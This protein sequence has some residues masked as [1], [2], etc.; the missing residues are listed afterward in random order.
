MTVTKAKR[1][2]WYTRR[3]GVMRG[4]YPEKQISRYILL[5][6]IRDGDE[7]RPEGGAWQSLA[8]F[9]ELIPEIMKLPP[10]EENQ[11]KLLMAQMREDERRPGD[12]R[13]RAPNTPA[14]LL[15]RR[16]GQE[17]RSAEADETVRHR[18]L[19]EQV[20][21]PAHGGK[22]LYRYPAVASAIVLF[23]L[24]ASYLLRQTEPEFVPPDCSAGARPGVNW[25]NCNLSGLRAENASLIG[26]R[27]QNARL[28]SVHLAGAVMTG[29]DLEYSSVNLGDLERADL[30]HSNLRGASLRGSNL[31]H[32]SFANAN[33]SY[34]NLSRAHIEG[35]D[36]SGAILD[37]TIWID[38]RTC[39]PGSLGACRRVPD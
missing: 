7:L 10:S 37:H 1:M 14:H 15:E 39:A 13:E 30:S 22:T 36:F 23:G 32:A 25:N 38:Q 21:H 9:P 18:E 24:L 35:A 27:I 26:A 19:R 3:N 33:L 17:R 29:A 16:R 4:P 11:Q 2:F 20:S 8:S 6:R 5:G 34:A 31:R 28:D 12:R